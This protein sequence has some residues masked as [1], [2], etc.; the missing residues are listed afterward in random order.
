MG[1]FIAQVIAAVRPELIRKLILA[2]TGPAG[3]AGIPTVTRVTYAD[4]IS[5]VLTGKDPKQ[6]LFFTR[7]ENGKTQARAF[8]ARLE[9]AHRRP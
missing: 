7:T 1:G 6:N 4:S 5:A 9:G 3:G 2:G 8:V